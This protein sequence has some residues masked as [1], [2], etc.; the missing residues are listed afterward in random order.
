MSVNSKSGFYIG[1]DIL[2]QKVGDIFAAVELGIIFGKKL[3][4]SALGF[5]A[6]G[7]DA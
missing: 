4:K 1:E 3:F 5:V 7:G 6:E 2:L